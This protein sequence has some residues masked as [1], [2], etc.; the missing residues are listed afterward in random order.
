MAL[1]ISL[2]PNDELPIDLEHLSQQTA[3]DVEL[4]A[5]VLRLFFGQVA[6]LMT[7]LEPGGDDRSWYEIA[8]TIKGASRGVGLLKLADLAEE[9]E[10]LMGSVA[11]TNRV[12]QYELI[13]EEFDRA[14]AFLE[15]NLPG[16]FDQ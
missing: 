7:T 10:A 16:F 3:G 11:L 8:H 9:A 6:D 4:Q 12:S 2:D 15:S 14:K 13:R 1:L 5:E